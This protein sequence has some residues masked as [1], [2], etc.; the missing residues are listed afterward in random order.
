M[1]LTPRQQR[2][3]ES[4]CDT[5]APAADG[6]PSAGALG[7]P[8]A[9]IESMETTLREEVR[10]AFL[11]LLSLWDSHLHALLA[12]RRLG[13]FSDLPLENRRDILLSWCDSALAPRR[14]AF[15]ALRK[16]AAPL[17]TM[18]PGPGG[19]RN[20]V[21]DHLHYPGPL[22]PQG[23]RAVERKIQ[24][25]RVDRD[26]ALDCD[27][28]VAGSGAGGGAAAGVLAAA[29]LDVVV[30]EAG[31]YYDDAD[32]DG[33]QLGGFRRLYWQGGGAATVDQ[34]MGL[35]AGE[36]L[37][38]GTVINYT[39]SFR[40]PDDVRAEWAAAGVP[41]IAREEYTR[42][43]D[44]VCARLSVNLEH[45][46]VS[47][48]ERILERGLRA[49]GWH[50]AAMPRN[51]RGCDQDKICG[52]CG[53]G[54]AIGAKQSATKTWLE[55]AAAAGA[56]ILTG[57]RAEK[58]LFEGG[59]ARG[60]LAYTT[61]GHEVKVKARA[62]VAACGGI[63][64]PALL[65]RSGLSNPHIG[66]HLHLHPVTVV[67]GIFDEEIRPWEGTLQAIYSDQHRCLSGNFGV[68]YETT[69]LHPALAAAFLPWRGPQPHR[70]LLASLPR[71]MGIG[72]LLRDRDG[73]SVRLDAGGEAEVRY[74]LSGFDLENLRAGFTGAAQILEAAG[75]RRIFS[76]HTQEVSYE[77]GRRG[78]VDEFRRGA[79]AC[80][81]GAG[82]C[83][84]YSFHIMGAA[85]LGGSPQTSA[86]NPDGETWE[87]K[88][89]S[90][91]D[92]CSFPSASGVNPMI[93]IEA[94]AH[95]N[96]L[97]LAARLGR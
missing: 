43:L 52:Y 60:V 3:L 77:P 62:V 54:C 56:R 25:L 53:F 63:Q 71:L 65:L 33:S 15:Q 96:A 94:I 76:S 5:F 85:R 68:K 38:G 9:I 59:K 45:N 13:R 7:V 29:G 69:A 87:A 97:A 34:S 64:T 51:V 10:G 28:C 74:A 39:T 24:P 19:G 81:W 2:A 90:V 46:R 41:W 89:L 91:M 37:G 21:W 47:A 14:A 83:V 8:A 23:R 48:R 11:R 49:L 55:D 6:W 50:V 27:V 67:W 32:F 36:C 95:R 66:R 72:I 84:F 58:V 88:N 92:A 80:G 18:L 75:A 61:G 93:S 82:Q 44:A 17:Y 20:P 12:A 42:S 79:D 31:R 40:T 16:A 70:E 22:L 26:T 35:L 86:C 1:P 78:N 57:T 73:G 30:L 4:I